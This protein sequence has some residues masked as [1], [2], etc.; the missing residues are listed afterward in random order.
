MAAGLM[1]QPGSKYHR[2]CQRS[3]QGRE[4]V[5]AHQQAATPGTVPQPAKRETLYVDDSIFLVH[6]GGS[7]GDGGDGGDGGGDIRAVRRPC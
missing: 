7:G 4:W 6:S 2:R 5:K 3:C 1:F